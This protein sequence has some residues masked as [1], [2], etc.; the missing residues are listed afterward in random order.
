M[1]LSGGQLQR[2]LLMREYAEN[3]P[4]MVLAEPGRGLD[5]RYWKKFSLLLR[6]RARA[7]TGIVIFSTDTES[8]LSISDEVMVLHNGLFTDSIPLTGPSSESGEA[9]ERLRRAMVGGA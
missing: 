9:R 1:S 7:G 8:L 6:E 3:T 4:L 2:I 5:A